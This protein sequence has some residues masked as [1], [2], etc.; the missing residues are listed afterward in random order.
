MSGGLFRLAL[1]P[2]AGVLATVACLT[3][4]SPTPQSFTIEAPAPQRTPSAGGVVV[5]MTRVE[6]APEYA[7]QAFVYQSA[8]HEL[9]RDPYA[10]FA[11][12][13]SLLLSTAVRDYLADADFI[14][15]VVSPDSGLRPKVTVETA[16]LKLSGVLRPTDSSSTLTLRFRV[17]LSPSEVVPA[18]A[19]LLK[20]YTSTTQ[21]PQATP[22]A[23]LGG[24]NQALSE[25]MG[26]FESDLRSSLVAARLLSPGSVGPTASRNPV[27]DEAGSPTSQ[28][29][30]TA[31]G[32]PRL[33]RLPPSTDPGP[34]R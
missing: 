21:N 6:V 10:R 12:M 8:E 7:G 25:V 16:A 18:T 2:A 9:I 28:R 27:G 3:P 26:L 31:T 30:K 20:T 34:N 4:R 5:A 17:L 32:A 23:V 19:I 14:S 24:W 11:A 15:D 29:T 13:P 33:Q 1:V 22:R